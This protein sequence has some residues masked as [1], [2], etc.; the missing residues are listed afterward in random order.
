MELKN[1]KFEFK[2][3]Q[4]HVLPKKWTKV[5]ADNIYQLLESV[6]DLVFDIT[7]S[8]I[9]ELVEELNEGLTIIYRD[10]VIRAID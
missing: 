8:E 1:Y 9:K 7:E 6:G 10:F 3:K 2:G 4:D 5:Y